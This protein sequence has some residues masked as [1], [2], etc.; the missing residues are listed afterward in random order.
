MST[1]SNTAP[2]ARRAKTGSAPKAP[3]TDNS[4]PVATD[5]AATVAKRRRT[6]PAVEPAAPVAPA[7]A[8]AK[9][10]GGKLGV[11]AAL[12]QRPEGATLAAMC[13]ATGWQAHSVRGAMAGALK[14]KFELVI[15]SDQSDGGRVYR[16]AAE[17]N[18]S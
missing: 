11:L 15:T 17:A 2:T 4:A 14:K 3:T 12:L 13:T 1:A 16:I 5:T 10:P 8:V 9:A 6:K 7:L 18:P